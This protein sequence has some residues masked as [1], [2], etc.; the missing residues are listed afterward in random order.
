MSG[1]ASIH[2]RRMVEDDTAA[3][4]AIICSNHGKEAVARFGDELMSSFMAYPHRPFVYVAVDKG[5]VVGCAS[6]LQNFISWASF[7]I[8]W[9]NVAPHR[10][11][12]GIGKLL[13]DRCLHDLRSE[14]D[15]VLLSTAS[16]AYYADHWG[17]EELRL[18]DNDPKHYLMALMMEAPHDHT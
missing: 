4:K 10:Q 7:S 13:V 3:L 8:T 14:A 6:F 15:I 1:P 11:R 18:I 12:Q 17:F 16:P 9:V 2:L 5:E